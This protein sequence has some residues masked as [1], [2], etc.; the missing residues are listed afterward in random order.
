[1]LDYSEGSI[2]YITRTSL[3]KLEDSNEQ[4]DI[5]LKEVYHR[6]KNNLN[7]TASMLGLQAMQESDEI[8]SHLLKSKSRIDAIATVHEMLYK[9]NNFNEINF[10][11][12]I[13][14]LESL[15]FKLYDRDKKF[16]LSI[17]V[18]KELVLPLDTMIKFGLMINEMFTNTIK[19][20]KNSKHLK[21]TI[22]LNRDNNSF[23]FIYK[24][25]GEI[26][27]D[28]NELNKHKG[29]GTKLIE[30]NTKQLDGQLTKYY[31]NGL[32]YEVR[33]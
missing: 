2:I 30:L 21:I 15:V 31:D 3:L 19:Y 28:I 25:N 1:M 32:C 20:A 16:T 14:K 7:L 23:A 12:Y 8:K 4:K 33:F 9:Q 18:D 29:L 11:D 27:I 17:D 24:D 22:S 26:I 6:V 10:Y 5:L 13:S